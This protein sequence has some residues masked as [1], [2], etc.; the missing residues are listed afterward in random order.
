MMESAPLGLYVHIPWCARRCIYCDFNTYVEDNNRLKA[1]YHAALQ[2]EIYQAGAALGRPPVETLYFGGGTPTTLPPEQLV[3]LV[4]EVKQAFT[5]LP[6]A[7]VTVEANPGTVTSAGLRAIRQGGVNRLSLGVQS[8][9]DAELHFLGRLHNAKTARH[10]VRQARQAGFNNL[11]LDL[12]FNLP[13]Q[14]PAHWVD[15]LRAALGLLPEH[16]SL[17]S[18][19]VEPGTPLHR[20]VSRG[21]VAAPDDDVAAEMYACASTMLAEAG[22]THYEISNWAKNGHQAAHNL[23][24][25]RNRPYL[26]VGAGAFSTVGAR[27]WMNVKHPRVYIRRVAAGKGLGLARDERTLEQIDPP[28]AMREHMLLGLRLVQEGVSAAGFETRFGV[29]LQSCYTEAIESGLKQGL[30]EWLN[31]ADG[32][33]LRLTPRGRFVANQVMIQFMA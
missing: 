29:S 8:F 3:E 30:L 32:P 21:Q 13:G 11:S 20:Q 31:A 28:T 4:N 23:I 16:I 26:G 14:T 1:R 12:M 19:I 22:Y 24:Y 9:R 5:L 25:W 15:T 6:H 18:L 7:E 10:A 27:R 33:H 2:Q 17:Y